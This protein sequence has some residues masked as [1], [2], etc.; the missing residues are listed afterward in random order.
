MG[1]GQIRLYIIGGFQKQTV[2]HIG[3]ISFIYYDGGGG[4]R[5]NKY[6][7]NMILI[8]NLKCTLALKGQC[9]HNQQGMESEC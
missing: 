9:R 1:E 6:V 4:L 7:I 2:L 5:I 3:K 8:N